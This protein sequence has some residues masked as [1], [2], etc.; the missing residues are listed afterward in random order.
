MTTFW[1]QSLIMKKTMKTE[2]SMN[3]IVATKQNTWRETDAWGRER[4]A[5]REVGREERMWRERER[6]GKGEKKGRGRRGRERERRERRREK[7][8]WKS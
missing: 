8:E 1:F 3:S 6:E 2:R 4:Q 7:G 5:G